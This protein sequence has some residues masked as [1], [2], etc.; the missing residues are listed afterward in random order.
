MPAASRK[1]TWDSV[2]PTVIANV[3]TLI[4]FK[5]EVSVG[6]GLGHCTSQRVV[7]QQSDSAAKNVP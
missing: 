6:N 1:H 2:L 7:F 3:I 4:A 5:I